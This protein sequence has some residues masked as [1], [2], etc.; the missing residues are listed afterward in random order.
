MT[1]APF[2][3]FGPDHLVV[4]AG[5]LAA[6]AGMARWGRRWTPAQRTWVGRILAFVLLAYIGVA[7]VRKAVTSGVS[8]GDSLPLHLCDLMVVACLIAL[9]RPSPLAAEIAYF[10]GLA[11]ALQAT[12]TPDLRLGF[13]AFLFF[14]F[15]WGHGG[16]LIAIV[17]LIAVQGFRPR[18]GSV[19]RMMLA[20]NLYVLVVG[21]IDWLTGWNYGYLRRPP[22][23]PSLLDHLGPWPW[24]IL[25]GE[26]LA[27]VSFW[28]LDLPWS[29]LRR[30]KGA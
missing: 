1:P 28:L 20:L 5:I 8:W 26:I 17:F 25:S 6:C 4:L 18:P 9:V 30:S 15:F 22:L 10:W 13:P 12:L 29:L 23:R 7:Y 21:L 27:L 11:G 14:H 19:W 24:Y 3:A 16:I 2:R